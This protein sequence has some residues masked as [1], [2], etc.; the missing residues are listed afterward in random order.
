MNDVARSELVA[1]ERRVAAAWTHG[2]ALVRRSRLVRAWPR[3]VSTRASDS[4]S[5]LSPSSLIAVTLELGEVAP[6]SEVAQAPAGELEQLVPRLGSRDAATQLGE[7]AQR[8]PRRVRAETSPVA[9]RRG[10]AAPSADP[11]T[12]MS[13]GT[14]NRRAGAVGSRMYERSQA[15]SAVRVTTPSPLG[16]GL[17][18]SGLKTI[19][20]T[21]KGGTVPRR[22]VMGR[23]N[24]WVR[25]GVV[26][27]VASLSLGTAT[28]AASA[29]TFERNAAT[30]GARAL[31]RVRIEGVRR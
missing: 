13:Q 19:S 14:I 3:M 22:I 20:P 16:M 25:L 5:T 10:S 24:R 17:C 1:G 2:I 21:V 30:D 28:V 9:S 8:A 29:S 18:R 27:I 31:K 12:S 7:R 15:I 4:V 6:E 23:L 11:M 26:I